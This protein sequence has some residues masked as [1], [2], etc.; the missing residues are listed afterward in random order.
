MAVLIDMDFPE[1]CSDCKLR[2]R[3]VYS[4]YVHDRCFVT[5]KRVDAWTFG[6][7][8]GRPENCPLGEVPARM[9]ADTEL[10]EAAGFEL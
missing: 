1:R 8:E 10:L 3:D 7:A 2:D 9:K 5:K 4:V 6:Y